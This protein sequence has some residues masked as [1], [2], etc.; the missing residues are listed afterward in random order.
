[1]TTLSFGAARETCRVMGHHIRGE[2]GF[3]ILAVLNFG[4]VLRVDNFL[5]HYRAR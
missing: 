3:G 2:S 4:L 5:Y 1:M